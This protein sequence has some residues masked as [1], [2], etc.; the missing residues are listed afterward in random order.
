LPSGRYWYIVQAVSHLVLFREFPLD[1]LD[2]I[3]NAVAGIYKIPAY[4]ARTKVRHGWGFL[5]RDLPEEEARRISNALTEQGIAAMAVPTAEL[6]HPPR[7]EVMVGFQPEAEGFI[8]QL[9]LPKTQPHPIAWSDVSI[10]AAGGFTEEI[11][12][13]DTAN[14]GKSGKEQLIGLGVFLVTGIPSGVFGSKKK[15][16]TPV[17]TNHPIT[18]AQILTVQGESFHLDPEHFDFSG[19]GQRKQVNAS[20]NFRTLIAEFARLTTARLNLGARHVLGNQSM[21]LANYQS[22]RDF[23]IELLW[24]L[25]TSA[26]T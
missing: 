11:V 18:F 1:K 21:T 5:E 10:L 9:H 6:I 22:L 7:P 2:A 16:P 13:R 17:K 14:A 19:L 8:P 25:N 3:A 20:L 12:R 23:E 4:D 24:L 15:E 26:A